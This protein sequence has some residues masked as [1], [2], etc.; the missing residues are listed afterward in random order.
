MFVILNNSEVKLTRY[1]IVYQKNL[2]NKT[3]VRNRY[4]N[5]IQ[6]VIHSK[7]CIS[8]EEKDR[9][10][11]SLI[12]QNIEFTTETID[13]TGNEWFDGLKFESSKEAHRVFNLGE[14][15]YKQELYQK[16]M[17]DGIKLRADIDYLAIMSGVEIWVGL[18]G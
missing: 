9:I 1:I 16:E 12:K 11:Q 8:N 10:E 3:F 18:I 13:Q 7:C 14:T 17:S 6:Q 15:A 4:N 2:K 5:Q